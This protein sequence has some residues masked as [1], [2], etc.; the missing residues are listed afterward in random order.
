MAELGP[1]AAGCWRRSL[2]TR[3]VVVTLLMAGVVV[4]LFTSLLLQSF[5]RGLVEA[6]TRA[7]LAEARSGVV[8]P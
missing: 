2:L 5:G 6:M 8:S 3:V 7:S 4:L 1:A